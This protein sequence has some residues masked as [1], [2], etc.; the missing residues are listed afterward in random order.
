MKPPLIERGFELIEQL[1]RV[2]SRYILDSFLQKG[3]AVCDR[4]AAQPFCIDCQR[5]LQ[6]HIN[7]YRPKSI[8]S[9]F[10]T[11]ALGAYD[12]AL[13]RAILA[14]KYEDRPK[15]A[16]FLGAE[17]ARKW[18]KALDPAKMKQ[19]CVVPIPLHTDRQRQRGY[20]QAA[21]LAQSFCQI[22]GL[23]LLENGL[24]RSQSTVPQHQL[25]LEA[26]QQNLSGAFEVGRSLQRLKV[27]TDAVDVLLIDD[28]YTTGVTVHNA[29]ETLA[30]AG[31]STIG[32]VVVARA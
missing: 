31:I 11:E 27:K 7:S 10:P 13:K 20:N 12:G 16:Q 25:G 17:L 15:T 32:V 23:R 19:I 9:P 4:A 22:S 8:A 24:V 5:Q 29:A 14:L 6:A 26:R 1:G 30:R 3:C 28:I 2:G 21:L 18:M